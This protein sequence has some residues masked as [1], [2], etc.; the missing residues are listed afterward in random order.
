MPV[1][2]F[3]KFI[4][5]AATETTPE[6]IELRISGDIIDDDDAW[7]YEWF[8]IPCASPNAFRDELSQYAGKDIT[9]WVN[10]NGGSVFA[11]A[12][13]YN[14][15]MEH[16][17]T[18]AKVTTKV[19]GKAMSAATIP[20]MA[21]DERL[22]SPVSLFMIHR[23][24]TEAQGYASDL[25]KAAD[26]LDTVKETIINAY[27]LG[28][29]L[30]RAKISSMMDDE[31]YMDAKTAIEQ[32]FAT[33]MLYNDASE[34]D[35]NSSILN[36]AFN[37]HAILNSADNAMKHL[38]EFESKN[39]S[40]INKPNS[41]QSKNG[42]EE[43]IVDS[44]ELKEK[45]PEIYN[46]VF[47]EGKKEGIT[48]GTTSERERIKGLDDLSGKIDNEFLTKAKYEEPLNAE[49]VALQAM[50]EDKMVN[51][52]YLNGIKND[53]QNANKVN[54]TVPPDNN[55]GE[56]DATILSAVKN[57]ADKTIKSL[58]GVK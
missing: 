16:K 18:G 1:N 21:G 32:K 13:I 20:Y 41:G 19:D 22:M 2:K 35:Q 14:A 23:P 47:A 43:T 52:A 38:L 28:T 9:V 39:K 45:Y 56:E 58:K 12:G 53:A 49:K 26:V 7:L 5:N 36:F 15:L 29:G 48:E 8:G 40:K 50:K 27:Q 57:I 17:K 37:R 11:A 44:K 42:E 46:E 3:W 54:G 30:S 31:S 34:P 6:S 10:S 51:T 25:R 55:K 33:G 4:K 24:I